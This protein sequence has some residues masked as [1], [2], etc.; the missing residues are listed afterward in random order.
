[1]FLDSPPHNAS[2][3]YVVVSR[4]CTYVCLISLCPTLP[5]TLPGS[6]ELSCNYCRNGPSDAATLRILCEMI[7]VG[8]IGLF[9][10]AHHLLETKPEP[11]LP[12]YCL[13]KLPSSHSLEVDLF[14]IL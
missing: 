2:R 1:M 5:G 3:G 12:A 6:Q 10:A 9:F 8:F 13:D 14:Y 7:T 4:T 11:F